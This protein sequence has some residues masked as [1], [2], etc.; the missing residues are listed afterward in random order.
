VR[1]S[2]ARR[3]DWKF[4]PVEYS[5]QTFRLNEEQIKNATV[6]SA[7]RCG[8]STARRADWRCNP[9]VHSVKFLPIFILQNFIL[10]FK[11]A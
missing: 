4:T 11:H 10:N 3:V 7:H 2:T 5:S 6:R 1:R 9:V 8:R